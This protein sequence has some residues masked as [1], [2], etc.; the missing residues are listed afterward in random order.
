MDLYIGIMSGTSMDAVDAV[1]LNVEA[2]PE[3]VA[4]VS[5]PFPKQLHQ[6]IS[7]LINTA[8]ISLADLGYLDVA[9]AELYSQAVKQL[10][11]KAH[12]QAAQIKAIGCHGQ[13]VFHQPEGKYRFS[14]QLG[15]GA[16]LTELTTITTVC[17]F[18]NRDIAAGGQGAPLVPVFH[19]ALFAH[20]NKDR[21]VIN[22]GGIANCTWLPV[23][24]E[25]SGFDIGPGNTLMDNWI[26]KC[27]N[28]SYDQDGKWAATGNISQPLL[29]LLL[30]DNFFHKTPPKSSGREY[31]NLS[32]LLKQSQELHHSLKQEDVQATLLQLTAQTIADTINQYQAPETYFCGGGSYNTQLINRINSLCDSEIFDVG[33]LGINPDQV[34]AAAFAWLAY[35]CMNGKTGNLPAVTGAKKSVISGT[36][37]QK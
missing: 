14:T 17:D 7:E 20:P 5:L 15:S 27:K 26:L 29:K 30:E 37:Y 18:R 9:L 19:Q 23:N 6:D 13:T 31:F 16:Y 3:I 12:L 33:E 8:N 11:L 36:I 24:G 32:W 2:T 21:L 25:V 10:L 22:V 28:Q 4:H 1:L 34:E 35:L